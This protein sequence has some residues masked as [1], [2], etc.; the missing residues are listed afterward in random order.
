MLEVPQNYVKRREKVFKTSKLK[1]AYALNIRD[2]KKIFKT[3]LIHSGTTYYNYLAN[4]KNINENT[5]V[6]HLHNYHNLLKF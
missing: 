3:S 6:F 4:L 1:N 5:L 2:L